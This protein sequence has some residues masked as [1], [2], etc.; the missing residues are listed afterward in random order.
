VK[1]KE[2]KNI[3][4]FQHLSIARHMPGLLQALV[5]HFG[6]GTSPSHPAALHPLNTVELFLSAMCK[7]HGRTTL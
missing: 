6:R 5:P 2:M 3:W 4:G 7:I 1:D